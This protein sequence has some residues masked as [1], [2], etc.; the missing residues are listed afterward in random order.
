[1]GGI[2]LRQK[3]IEIRLYEELNAG[4]KIQLVGGNGSLGLVGKYKKAR[5][6]EW[7]FLPEFY[8]RLVSAVDKTSNSIVGFI[9][10]G[11]CVSAIYVLERYGKEGIG[12]SLLY[13]VLEYMHNKYE[14]IKGITIERPTSAVKKILEKIVEDSPD[15]GLKEIRGNFTDYR[16]EFLDRS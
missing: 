5:D 6:D 4:Q 14:D 10:L 11:P 2:K 3:N 8:N 13:W 15:K 1:M 12:T 7:E 16:I 9:N